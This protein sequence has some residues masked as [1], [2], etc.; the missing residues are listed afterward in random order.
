MYAI[1]LASIQWTL[2][3]HS[4]GCGKSLE[5]ASKISKCISQCQPGNL[6]ST[7]K[8][9]CRCSHRGATQVAATCQV[10][11]LHLQSQSLLFT[12]NL[13]IGSTQ[14]KYQSKSIVSFL[15]ITLQK[16]PQFGTTNAKV[17][18][19]TRWTDCWMPTLRL[20]T[21]YASQ[22]AKWYLFE[23]SPTKEPERTRSVSK[24]ST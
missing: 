9:R 14:I 10:P 12:R 13:F 22:P 8:F 20:T 1:T 19:Q 11:C 24:N 15:V 2:E 3:N 16:V 17:P 18:M 5:S 7:Q 6:F 4:K 21:C 23:V